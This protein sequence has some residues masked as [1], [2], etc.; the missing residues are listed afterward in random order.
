[1]CSKQALPHLLVSYWHTVMIITCSFMKTFDRIHIKYKVYFFLILHIS[2]LWWGVL[3]WDFGAR[4]ILRTLPPKKANVCHVMV[5]SQTVHIGLL[6]YLTCKFIYLRWEMESK[7]GTVW[8]FQVSQC[9]QNRQKMYVYSHCDCVILSIYILPH[10]CPFG[11]RL[12]VVGHNHKIMIYLF[13]HH[14]YMTWNAHI[15][16]FIWIKLEINWLNHTF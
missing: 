2:D 12:H 4:K 13:I 11:Q 14:L 5:L 7:I 8:S 16:L 1:M 10:L 15:H 9:L 6:S 3:C